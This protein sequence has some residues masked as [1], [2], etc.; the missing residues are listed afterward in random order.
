MPTHERNGSAICQRRG[1]WAVVVTIV[2]DSMKSAFLR[3]V[4][5][6]GSMYLHHLLFVMVENC[7]GVSQNVYNKNAY[8]EE[9]RCICRAFYIVE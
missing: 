1:L 9:K 5:L 8:A 2:P 6:E 4:K 7:G 3:D